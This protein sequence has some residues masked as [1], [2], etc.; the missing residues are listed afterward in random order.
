MHIF[1]NR[2]KYF[3]GTP[4]SAN[5][6]VGD[7]QVGESG[8]MNGFISEKQEHLFLRINCVYLLLVSF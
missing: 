1:A 5:R 6:M 7:G 2:T 8:G 3:I 4:D